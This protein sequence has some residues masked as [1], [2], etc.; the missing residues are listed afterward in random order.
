VYLGLNL[1]TGELIAVKLVELVGDINL[2]RAEVLIFNKNTF[3]KQ[4]KNFFA[5]VRERE[6][7]KERKKE[8]KKEKEIKIRNER[9]E[10]CKRWHPQ[11]R[12]RLILLHVR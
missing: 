6:R 1:D 12:E 11:Q 3:E 7:E 4:N 5:Y 10:M 2:H 8:R 9:K